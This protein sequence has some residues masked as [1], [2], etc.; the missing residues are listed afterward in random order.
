M[1]AGSFRK[2]YATRPNRNH[3]GAMPVGIYIKIEPVVTLFIA[4]ILLGEIMGPGQ[5]IGAALVLAAIIWNSTDKA[6]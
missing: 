2:I 1:R 6:V 4:A 5:M 3:I